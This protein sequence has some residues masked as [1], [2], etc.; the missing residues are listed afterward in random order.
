M[1]VPCSAR[2]KVKELSEMPISSLFGFIK[3]S[4]ALSLEELETVEDVEGNGKVKLS[5]LALVSQC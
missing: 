1:S 3:A 4:A 2:E 5:L